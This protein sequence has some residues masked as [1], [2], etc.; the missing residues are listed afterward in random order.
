MDPA[1]S[2]IVGYLCSFTHVDIVGIIRMAPTSR[3]G[4]SI[5][6]AFLASTQKLPDTTV[7]L[8]GVD[9]ILI[10]SDTPRRPG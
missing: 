1:S 7:L 8:L 9:V 2:F 4:S 6:L 5:C 3:V 10:F